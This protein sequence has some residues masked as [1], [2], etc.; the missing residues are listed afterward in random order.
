MEV[1]T[2]ENEAKREGNEYVLDRKKIC[3]TSRK[4]TLESSGPS[5]EMAGNGEVNE[6][7]NEHL[8]LEDSGNLM[9][10]EGAKSELKHM[11]KESNWVQDKL[12]GT[13]RKLS[14]E[15]FAQLQKRNDNEK[16]NVVS[17]HVSS[18]MSKDLPVASLG[19]LM[20][21]DADSSREKLHRIQDSISI[22]DNINT[23]P[24]KLRGFCQKLP[25]GSSET[26]DVTK[27]K[28]LVISQLLSSEIHA[29]TLDEGASVTA[30]PNH[31]KLQSQK[32]LVD[33]IE[34]DSY[35][36][37]HKRFSVG[38]KLSL[39]LRGSSGTHKENVEPVQKSH[40]SVA[41][42]V[43][44]A[45][46]P[47]KENGSES[48]YANHERHGRGQKQSLS[49]LAQ[50]QESNNNHI[51]QQD[52]GWDKKQC[53]DQGQNDKLKGTEESLMAEAVIV[54]DSED[55][56]E[57]KSMPLMSKPLLARKRLG[58]WKLRA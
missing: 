56:E 26:I 57:E 27:E 6:A 28:I 8:L 19:S 13:R 37:S 18:C 24:K 21:Q 32:A 46:P 16:E 54:L 9:E 15:G 5:Q 25:L 35:H 20:P 7:S 50:L 14:L 40:S 39:G 55:S 44:A 41:L 49:P 4:L 30:A 45:K 11:I 17:N 2:K 29:N 36:T 1:K 53:S 10:V 38:K 51:Q 12:K 43:S 52:S 48:G 22:D 47:V 23:K 34:N 33:R 42:S 31:F 58:K 3:G